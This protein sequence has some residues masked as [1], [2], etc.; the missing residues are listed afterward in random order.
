MARRA[1][2]KV[3]G[4]ESCCSPPVKPHHNSVVMPGGLEAAENAYRSM[5]YS[6][7]SKRKN[8]VNRT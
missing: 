3:C 5:R 7:N 4:M 2:D 6:R 8:H 1:P